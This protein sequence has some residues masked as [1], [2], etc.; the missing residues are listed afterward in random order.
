MAN[1]GQ[2]NTWNTLNLKRDMLW[3]GQFWGAS[4]HDLKVPPAPYGGEHS[5]HPTVFAYAQPHLLPEPSFMPNAIV[6]IG[7]DGGATHSRLLAIS[8]NSKPIERT[9][10]G[11]NLQRVGIPQTVERLA[12]LIEHVFTHFSSDTQFRLAICIGWPVEDVL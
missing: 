7:I 11:V 3:S 1:L 10:P 9:G 6:H 2:T 8:P 12:L 5:L 4:G